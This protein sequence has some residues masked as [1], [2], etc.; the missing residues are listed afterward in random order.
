MHFA[1]FLAHTVVDLGLLQDYKDE[2]RPLKRFIKL[3]IALQFL[4]VDRVIPL[5]HVIVSTEVQSPY[6]VPDGKCNHPQLR[7]FLDYY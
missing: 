1:F 6:V 5:F 4:T 2:T 3:L 7:A